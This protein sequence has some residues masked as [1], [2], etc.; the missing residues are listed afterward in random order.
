[1]YSSDNIKFSN[2]TEVPTESEAMYLGCTINDTKDAR[3]ELSERMRICNVIWRK[4]GILW[5]QSNCTK[6]FKLRVYDAVVRTKLLY[7]LD[8]RAK[9]EARRIPATWT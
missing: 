8:R 3:R 2:G 5:K 6:A 9:S 1:M 4:L 7:G